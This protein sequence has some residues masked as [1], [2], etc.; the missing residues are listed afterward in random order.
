MK[1]HYGLGP[2]QIEDIRYDYD[3]PHGCQR[4]LVITPELVYV[5]HQIGNQWVIAGNLGAK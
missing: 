3:G 2:D 5:Y 1:T 4:K